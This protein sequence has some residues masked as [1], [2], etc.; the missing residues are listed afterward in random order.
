MSSASA[1]AMNACKI[2]NNFAHMTIAAHRTNYRISRSG[3]NCVP[4]SMQNLVPPP[5]PL[6]LLLSSGA[7]D[8]IGFFSSCICTHDGICASSCGAILPK[9]PPNGSSSATL[10]SQAIGRRAPHR[11]APPQG[12][13]ARAAPPRPPSRWPSLAPRVRAPRSRPR[14]RTARRQSSDD[15]HAEK[16]GVYLIDVAHSLLVEPHGDRRCFSPPTIL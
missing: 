8:F 14:S 4:H 1:S 11:R 12:R 6:L 5:P 13:A 7:A 15:G 2:S 3:G 16:A 10:A 9:M